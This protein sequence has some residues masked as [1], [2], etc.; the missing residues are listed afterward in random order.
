M[1]LYGNM[2]YEHHKDLPLSLLC[3]FKFI[4]IPDLISGL[5]LGLCSANDRRRYKVT[6]SLIGWG[7]PRISPVILMTLDCAS[8]YNS[9]LIYCIIFQ[10]VM[11]SQRL[12]HLPTARTLL[13]I[14]VN[15][16]PY[17]NKPCVTPVNCFHT[18]CI[19]AFS[20]PKSSWLTAATKSHRHLQVWYWWVTATQSS[21]AKKLSSYQYNALQGH[22]LNI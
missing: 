17:V 3:F 10:F 20:R 21:W 1:A 5:I 19:F 4:M 2:K 6:P 9:K 8:I 22:N 15:Q 12:I 16:C 11:S 14:G 7:K 13:P 18:R